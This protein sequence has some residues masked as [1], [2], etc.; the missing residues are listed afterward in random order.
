MKRCGNGRTPRIGH[1]TQWRQRMRVD[2]VDTCEAAATKLTATSITGSAISDGCLS[3]TTS[4]GGPAAAQMHQ[5]IGTLRTQVQGALAVP[6]P[7]DE[8]T[9]LVDTR[10]LGK[11][12]FFDTRGQIGADGLTPH[13]RLKGRAFRKLLP[14]FGESV[15]HLSIGKSAS[16]LLERWSDGL[17]LCVVGMSSEFYVGTALGVVRARSLRRRPLEDKC[18]TP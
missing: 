10:L 2:G 15:L 13:Q 17:F 6:L 16:R 1:G 12:K 3:R 8:S 9:N 4:A 11:P 14:V 18:G 7:Q 5:E